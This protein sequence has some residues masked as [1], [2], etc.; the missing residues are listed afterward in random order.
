MKLSLEQL[1]GLSI[2]GEAADGQEGVAKTKELKPQVV[3][4]DIEMPVMDG[5]EATKA[6]K[7]LDLGCEHHYAHFS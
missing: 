3:L 7:N 5:I 2:V 4:M 1:S 6:I